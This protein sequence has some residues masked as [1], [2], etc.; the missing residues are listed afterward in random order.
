[1][2]ISLAADER[3]GVADTAPSD[4]PVDVDNIRHVDQ[5]A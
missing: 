4:D 2:R 5:I 3:T 1:V